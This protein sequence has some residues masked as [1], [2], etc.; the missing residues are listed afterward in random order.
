MRCKVER[1]CRKS[2]RSACSS[3]FEMPGTTM[4]TSKTRSYPRS[5]MQQDTRSADF[6]AEVYPGPLYALG[7][8]T[9]EDTK[10]D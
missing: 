8:I 10:G 5:R 2:L 1:I 4:P 6:T 9:F 7:E 3:I